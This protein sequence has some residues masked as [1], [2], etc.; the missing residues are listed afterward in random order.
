MFQN[1]TPDEIFKIALTIGGAVV[2]LAI[3]AV[4]GYY[5]FVGRAARADEAGWE[6]DDAYWQ[7][8]PEADPEV[9][10]AA[11]AT[12][13][14]SAVTN[15]A[16]DKRE[17]RSERNE[18]RKREGRYV[19]RHSAK[20]LADL[21]HASEQSAVE[22]PVP[23]GPVTAGSRAGRSAATANEGGWIRP[24]IPVATSQADA[25]V[26]PARGWSDIPSQRPVPVGNAVAKIRRITPRDETDQSA[27]GQDVL[28][29]LV[30]IVPDNSGDDTSVHTRSFGVPVGYSPDAPYG[31]MP[32]T[33]ATLYL[34]A[35]HGF[36]VPRS[37]PSTQE[38]AVVRPE[39]SAGS[40][41][42]KRPARVRRGGPLSGYRRVSGGRRIAGDPLNPEETNPDG[43]LIDPVADFDALIAAC[44]AG[45]AA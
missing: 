23:V 6:R 34:A 19:G 4:L 8:N 20:G 3:L 5:I 21:A 17:V 37:G 36:N 30:R 15:A 38:I 26:A 45:A 11:G 7:G 33:K 39:G 2:V 16:A 27:R 18:S 12:A 43:S 44:Y 28:I 40:A 9:S 32:G 41:V 13:V 14:L 1:K 29:P 42:A 10:D 25:E 24:Q 22:G 35:S 31:G